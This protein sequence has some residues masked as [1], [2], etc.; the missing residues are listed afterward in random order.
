MKIQI[1]GVTFLIA[2]T[3]IAAPI[4]TEFTYQ[5]VL[6]DAGAPA[7]GVF[8]FRFFL[9]NADAGGSQV[10]PVVLVEDLTVT[11]GRFT[12]QLDFGPV[13]DGTALWLEV[14]V[15]DGGAGGSYTVL[16][17]RQE[18]TAAPFAQHAQAADMATAATTAG[19]AT[20][21]GEADTLDGQHGAY[22][23]SW[24]NF[25]GIPGDLADGD[26]DTLADLSCSPDEIASWNG[27][28][29]NCSSD[30]DTPYT[31]TF[32]VGPVGT[33]TENGTAL[34]N[35][36]AAITPP[37]SQEEAVL[38]KLEPGVYDVGSTG[39]E[40]WGWMTIEGAGE[41]LTTITGSVCYSTGPTVLA[42]HQYAGL[43]RLTVENT[44][45]DPGQTAVAFA[46][47]AD[48]VTVDQCSFRADT[49]AGVVY[50]VNSTGS[51][52]KMSHATIVASQGWNDVV[53]L[54]NTGADA[55]LSDVH[56]EADGA[57]GPSLAI[58]N[59]G[60]DFSINDG[61]LDARGSSDTCTAFKNSGDSFSVQNS[62]LTTQFCPE[63]SVGLESS[64]STGTLRDVWIGAVYG[65]Q[66][67]GT[68]GDVSVYDSQ[69]IGDV[70]GVWSFATSTI[71]I[72][73]SFVSGGINSIAR[74]DGIVNLQSVILGGGPVWGT[75]TC[76]ACM[77]NGTFNASVCP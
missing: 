65:I 44:C 68:G 22:Y 27:S 46:P 39:I 67:T 49:Q 26:D 31:R 36:I 45:A 33:T 41:D 12:S 37:T 24:S 77:R 76:T 5:G 10:G 56:V 14:G 20:T 55:T 43:R 40:M 69:V 48:Y 4:G 21:A 3:V 61:F 16:Q 63:V 11:D 1:I 15:R 23:L 8:D 19:H 66:T 60:T 62:F 59:S 73:H 2:A 17:P 38:L 9:Y 30:D 51:S 54:R 34:R 47:T 13:F 70:Y 75:V 35:A 64:D 71:N 50:C 52:L 7:S 25:T 6:S 28:A 72:R 74:T 29:W 53:G 58:H 42:D 18:L 32:V 57:F